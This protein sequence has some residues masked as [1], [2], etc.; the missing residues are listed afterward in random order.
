M[1]TSRQNPR[2]SQRRRD[3]VTR[4]VR[5]LA[6]AVTVMILWLTLAPDGPSLPTRMA[7]VDKLWHALAFFGWAMLI[8]AGW[9]CPAWV[10]LAGGL[11][12]GGAIEVIQP[13][14]G[15]DAELADLAA[16]LL[17]AGLGLWAGAR[18]RG[19]IRSAPARPVVT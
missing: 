13:L 5:L 15:R 18:L 8:A 2:A 6:W 16:D 10:V 9:R 19:V 12:L 4:A 11:C 7:H 17:G 1:Q 14:A 3:L